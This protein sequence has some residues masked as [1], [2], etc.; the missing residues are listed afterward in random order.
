LWK[1]VAA[2]LVAIMLAGLPGI[3]QAYRAPTKAEVDYI[4]QRQDTVLVRLAAIDEKLLNNRELIEE[5]QRRL[6]LHE[7]RT[8][9]QR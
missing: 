2:I 7:Q 6:E 5:I 3:I 4:R 8:G 1:W 9:L